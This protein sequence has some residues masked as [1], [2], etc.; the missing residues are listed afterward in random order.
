MTQLVIAKLQEKMKEKNTI[1]VVCCQMPKKGLIA[2]V[3]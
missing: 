3:F 2:E 1:K